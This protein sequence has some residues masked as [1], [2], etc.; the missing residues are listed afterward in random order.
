[1]NSGKFKIPVI[2]PVMLLVL[3]LL[4]A[5]ICAQ[6]EMPAVHR[7]SV[8]VDLHSDVL[9]QV[10]RG[11]D[12][13]LR[14]DD[15]QVDLVRLREGGVDVQFFAV[16]PD[17]GKYYPGK[18]FSQAMY[19]IDRLDALIAAH[20]DRIELA[21]SA[22]DIDRIVT[23]GRLAACIGVEGGTAIE[24]DLAKLDSLY[25]RGVRYLGL[26]WNDSHDWATSARDEYKQTTGDRSGLSEFGRDVIR[27]MNQLGMIVDVSHAGEQTFRDV[28]AVSDKPVIASHSD[29]FALR[30]HYRNLKDWQIRAIAEKGG[31][32]GINFYPS[33]LDYSFA[34]ALEEALDRSKAHLDSMRSVY[35][36]NY[37]A[38]RAYRSDYLRR[39][40]GKIPS[41]RN[42]ADH[43]DYIVA[44]VGEDY[45]ALGSDFDGI[46]IT[47]EG[48]EDVSKMPNITAELLRR[49]YSDQRIAKI[50]GG[51]FLRV[52]RAQQN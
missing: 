20:Q 30:H 40:I 28:M 32:I 3:A 29:V 24:N 37:R 44:L 39:M 46:S 14:L 10:L 7:R 19:M 51:N 12:I 6:S 36:G 22:D 8:V 41:V 38:Y 42:V 47:P 5:T 34:V 13:S 33:Y 35:A 23:A 15:G 48:L 50:L 21:R 16:W 26:T 11:A 49:G 31:V 9:L 52:M 43:I 2:R 45:V 1:M 18:M 27:H 25:R 17:P 4:P